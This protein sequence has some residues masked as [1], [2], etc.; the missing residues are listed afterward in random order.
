MTD[1]S[2]GYVYREGDE[3]RVAQRLVR[4]GRLEMRDRSDARY[5]YTERRVEEAIQ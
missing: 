1:A 4:Q 5:T 3:E 2:P